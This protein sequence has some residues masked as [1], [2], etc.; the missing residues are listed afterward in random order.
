MSRFGIMGILIALVLVAFA[1]TPANAYHSRRGYNHHHNSQH[2]SYRGTDACAFTMIGRQVCNMKYQA[3]QPTVPNAAGNRTFAMSDVGTI[4][5]SRPS[6]CPHSYCGCGLRKY[7]GISDVRLNLA[8]NWARLLP[9]EAAPRPGLAAVR[10]GHVM[11]IEAAAGNGQW[12]IRDYNS[13]SGLSRMHVR[14]VR[15]YVFVNPHGQLAS[16]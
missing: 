10:S 6:D 11:Y 14:D 16:R 2:L 1:S 13:G 3:L 7:L 4:I 8:S 5:G 15:G 9:R 12:L